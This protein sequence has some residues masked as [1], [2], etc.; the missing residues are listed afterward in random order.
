MADQL[1]LFKIV[2]GSRVAVVDMATSEVLKSGIA[3]ATGK[4]SYGSPHSRDIRIHVRHIDYVF[5][6]RD[7]HLDSRDSRHID[8]YQITDRYFEPVPE[9]YGKPFWMRALRFLGFK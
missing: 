5:W 4:F 8:V 9:S 1:Q 6:A 2:P 3:P 7:M